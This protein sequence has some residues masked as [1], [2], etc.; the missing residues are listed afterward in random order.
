MTTR[1][2]SR[3]SVQFAMTF[4]APRLAF[5]LISGALTLQAQTAPP[6]PKPS[7]DVARR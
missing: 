6:T 4:R 1:I 2:S 5:F 7:P 3:L